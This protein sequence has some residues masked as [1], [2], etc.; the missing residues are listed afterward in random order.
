MNTEELESA[1]KILGENILSD[2]RKASRKGMHPD[3]ITDRLLGWGMKQDNLKVALFRFVDVLPS[4]DDPNTIVR[5]AQ[6]YFAPLKNTLPRLLG[7][8][9]DWRSGR[10]TSSPIAAIAQRAIRS[11]ASQFIVGETPM[12]ALEKLRAIRKKGRGFTIDILGEATLSETEAQRYLEQYLELLE[13]LHNAVPVWSE[14][15]PIIDSHPGEQRVINISVKLSALYSQTSPLASDISIAI[16]SETLSKIFRKAIDCNAFV[17][18][19]MEDTSFTSI[20]IDT[21]KKTLS[22]PEFS[23]W[24][25]A[26]IVLQA[27]LKRTAADLDGLIEFARARNIPF[28]IRLVKGA[29]WDTETLLSSQHGWPNPVW[30]R[31]QQ[32][33]MAYEKLT[34]LLLKNIDYVYPAFA[35]HNIRSLCHAVCLAEM[36]GVAKNSYELQSLY[37]MAEPVKNWFANNG[38]LVREYAPVGAMIPGMSY[39]VRRLLEN[40][41]NESFLKKTF[42]DELSNDELLGNPAANSAHTL[43]PVSKD[44]PKNSFVNTPLL[45]FSEEDKRTQ[46]LASLREQERKLLNCPVSVKPIIGNLEISRPINDTSVMPDIPTRVIANISNA[47]E[48][49]TL[50]ALEML[51]AS[52]PTW[53]N[54]PVKE[55]SAVLLKA[56]DIIEKERI[57]LAALITIEAGKPWLEADKDVA[58]AIDFCRYYAL[59]AETLF[60]P[61]VMGSAP[62]ESNIYSYEPRGV[63]AVIAPWNFPLAIP[64]G[65][66]A[67]ALVTGNTVALKPAEQTPLIAQT[68]FK[69]FLAA[70]TPDNCIAFLPGPG[71]TIGRLLVTNGKVETIVFT[72]SKD[73]GLE[74]IQEASKVKPE[75]RHIKRVIVELGGKNAIIIDESADLDEAVAGVIYSAFGYAGQKCSAASRIIVHESIW[76]TLLERLARA[77]ESINILPATD[78]ACYLGPVIDSVSANRLRLKIAQATKDCQSLLTKEF[79]LP[80]EGRIPEEE[81]CYLAPAIFCNIPE[82]HF[83]LNEELFGPVI[84]VI[85]AESFTDAIGIALDTPYGLTGAVYSRSPINIAIAIEEFRT[86]N[87]YINR[88]STG[89]LVERQPF[90]GAYMSGVGSKAGGPDYLMQFVIPRVVTENTIRRGFAPSEEYSKVTGE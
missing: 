19:D 33:D 44:K 32:T 39:L 54:T 14:S 60:R 70:G 89:A 38:Y 87:L 2:I 21:F 79:K 71:E 24:D 73:V 10:I 15:L 53:R 3:F 26:G 27:Y 13:T 74:I 30:S 69:I 47:T 8:L 42:H 75:Q 57:S 48:G 78:P 90:G 58:E 37:G 35:S 46:Y 12:Q 66:F 36:L 65:M 82:G 81:S 50:V 43:A 72:G 80:C 5:I 16:L 34:E 49:D 56:A 59:Q 40:T 67:A 18:L 45:D 85:K 31:K 41:S 11:V 62:G 63:A 22:L 51:S 29:Y 55:R 25:G 83:L 77:V 17:Y 9:L 76:D 4:L 6:E 28:A 64:C 52:F 61:Q 23:S 86:G 20:I 68:L 88:S 7:G 84:A 1:I